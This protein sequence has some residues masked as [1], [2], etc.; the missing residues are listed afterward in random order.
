MR[1]EVLPGLPAYGPMAISFTK[2]GAR[3]HREGLV[4]RFYP[5]ESEPWVGNFVGD[6]TACNI[7]LE[8]PNKTHII[9]VAR[10]EAHIVDPERRAVIDRL[11]FDVHQVIPVPSLGSV[12]FQGAIDFIAI[13][14]DK[15]GWISPRISWDGFRNI[16]VR[17]TELFGEAYSSIN[18][19]WAPFKLD[20]L[21]GRCTDGTYELD[22]G[23][24]TIPR[25][26]N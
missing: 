26:L 20:L 2:N 9:V 23:Q 15:S 13:R 17:E 12:I 24:P 18:D 5:R 1:F 16:K 11:S 25:S 22:I 7:V 21:T 19:I 8:H 10:G 3:E 4:V 6:L 14:A